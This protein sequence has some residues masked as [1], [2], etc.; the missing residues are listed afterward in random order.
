MQHYYS[1]LKN[2][3]IEPTKLQELKTKISLKWQRYCLK[4]QESKSI[5]K[6]SIQYAFTSRKGTREWKEVLRW[7]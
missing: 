1:N 7:L 6:A 5:I 2:I 3:K 4:L